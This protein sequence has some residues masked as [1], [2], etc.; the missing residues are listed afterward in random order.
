M[1]LCNKARHERNQLVHRQCM[2]AGTL[3]K[4]ET[5]MRCLFFPLLF[6]ICDLKKTFSSSLYV[7]NASDKINSIRVCPVDEKKYLHC[8]ATYQNLGL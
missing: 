3:G 1:N 7:L 6:L 5:K 8:D 2:C 4:K